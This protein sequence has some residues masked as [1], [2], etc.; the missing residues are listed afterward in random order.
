MRRRSFRSALAG[1]TVLAVGLCA[2]A[3][4]ADDAGI[5]AGDGATTVEGVVVTSAQQSSSVVNGL[6]LSLRETPQSVTVIP[7]EQIEA[8]A[9][10]DANQLLAQAVGINVEKVET[11]RTYYN[12]RGFDIT[13][14]QVDGVGLPLI[15]GIQFG[16]LD[17]A[18]FDRVEVI[19]GADAMMT[20]TGNPSAT[21]NYV[22]KR[23]TADFRAL[24]SV[25]Y[26]SWGDWRLEADVSGPLSKDGALSGR[27]VY[28]NEDRG[29]YLDDYQQNRNLLYGVAT[30][31]VSPR[32]AFT[33]GYSV[34]D[35]RSRGVLWGALPL[36]YSDGSP[37]DYPVSA[38]SSADWTFWN[39]RDQQAFAE[40][41]YDFEGGWKLKAI[42]TY[43]RFDELAKLL[44]AFNYPDPA[45]GLGVQGMSGVY[46]SHY[47][48]YL[49]DAYASGPLRLFGREHQLVFGADASHN[50]GREYVDFFGGL[51][52]YPAVWDWGRL[53]PAEPAYPGAYLA[54]DQTDRMYRAYAAGHF[55]LAPRLKAMI[56]L[57]WVSLKSEG[58]SYGVDQARDERKLSPYAGAV[59]ELTGNV[60]AYASYTD[61]FNPQA[62]V[63][64]N[65]RTLPAAHGKSYEAG[66]KSEWFGKR[67]LASAAVFKSDQA[68]LADFAGVFPDGKSYYAGIDTFVTG[69]EL[70]V[71][72][73]LTD[74]WTVGGGWTQLRIR[75]A[76]DQDVRL[77]LPRRT[78]K[79]QTTYAFP[80]LR[81]LQLGAALRWQSAVA[82]QDIVLVEQKAYAELDLMAGIDV[83]DRVRATVNVKNVTDN[84]HLTSLMWNQSY[85][86]APRSW[87]LRLSY[88]F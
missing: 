31:A 30:W 86:A 28:A 27:L 8:F 70:E 40:A 12:A 46:P 23:P 59:L 50:H 16:D 4:M 29:S 10:T 60:S 43:K 11:D 33:A 64:I 9:L 82:M 72:G 37:V 42:A 68:G 15:W 81:D 14:F 67:L 77:Y 41:A 69:Y 49:L 75:D 71:A 1:A 78:L 25:Q 80:G 84:K 65:H 47:N 44:Y 45:T 7:R 61:V 24:G 83:A 56:G 38:S 53:Q 26:G 66:L 52:D 20:G 62:D 2:G 54:A 19:R 63:D 32:L 36:T 34:Q 48:Q 22:R 5:E 51:I 39:V 79:L 21:V 57:S 17:T 13:N 73:N 87:S 55:D 58:V 88:S 35:N 18:I 6:D 3:A 85:Y 74:R 76:D